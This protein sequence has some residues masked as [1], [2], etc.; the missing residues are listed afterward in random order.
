MQRV[1]TFA[2]IPPRSWPPNQ[3]RA[4]THAATT[5][6]Q[7]QRGNPSVCVKYML[8]VWIWPRL[9]QLKINSRS[10]FQVHRV[11]LCPVRRAMCMQRISPRTMLALKTEHEF[12]TSSSLFCP[13]LHSVGRQ[14]CIA[15]NKN[16]ILRWIL[17]VFF[18]ALN[19]SPCLF[20]S[21]CSHRCGGVLQLHGGIWSC[22][23]LFPTQKCCSFFVAKTVPSERGIP[24]FSREQ[25]FIS[26]YSCSVTGNARM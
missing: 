14:S 20:R 1:H 3:A 19:N 6:R 17:I 22:Y 11:C 25:P 18:I 23:L 2:H 4:L 24:F 7:R 15:E 9:L 12:R 26:I 21:T 8:F 16:Q 10:V 13:S 5:W